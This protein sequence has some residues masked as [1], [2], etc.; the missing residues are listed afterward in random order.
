MRQLTRRVIARLRGGGE[1]DGGASSDDLRRTHELYY[2]AF[3]GQ[4]RNGMVLADATSMRVIDVNPALLS[5]TGFSRR[6]MAGLTLEDLFACNDSSGTSLALQ[7]ADA[8]NG[9]V[10]RWR[11][12]RTNAELVEVEV[13]GHTV[14]FE[15][16]QILALVIHDASVRRKVEAHSI[17]NQQ[18][19]D[20]LAHHDQLTGL[21]NRHYLAA[22]LPEAIAKAQVSGSTLAILFIDLDHFKNVNDS[23]GHEVGDK[24]LQEVAR[25]IVENTSSDDTVVRMGGD[26]FIVVVRPTPEASDGQQTAR[27]INR[28]LD[29]PINVNG[30][31]LVATASIG[32]SV[33]PRDGADMGELL[34]HSDSAMY[35]A[36]ET[37]RNQFQMFR[38]DMVEKVQKRVALEG[39]LR[40]AIKRNQFDVSY[41]PI[42]DLRSQRVAGLEALVRWIH[43]TR[44]T[45]APDQFIEVAED[46]G[47][48][49]P[50]G[51]FVL[52]HVMQDLH[53]WQAAGLPLVPVSINI[54]AAQLNQGDL[55]NVIAKLLAANGFGPEV[56][57]LELT[58]RAMFVAGGSRRSDSHRDM[59]AE[60]RASGVRISLDDFGTGYSSLS[61]LKQWHVDKLKIDRSFIRDVV[62]DPNDFAI[63]SAILAIARQMRIEVV[64]EGIESY[65]QVQKLEP[66]GCR[67]GQGYLF[68]MPKPAEDCTQLLKSVRPAPES[69]PDMYPNL[70][71]ET[72]RLVMPAAFRRG[73]GS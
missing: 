41:Q 66:L 39:A 8:R 43:P 55:A 36:K 24:L 3:A 27:R 17:E 12:K 1:G 47:L 45:I 9:T 15:G 34:K 56:I 14:T 10:F 28:A 30:H 18:R 31:S 49:V 42:I 67:F 26:E 11:E 62:H 53:T 65:Q 6:D 2:Q 46:S 70:L 38:A 21:P 33:Y 54:S 13:R 58:E 63:V 35:Q 72:G 44:G 73:Q 71:D 32:V 51:A 40:A 20:H 23:R 57:E 59:I 29:Q 61:Y 60:L 48:I 25:R 50:I 64:A 19:L 5:R 69:E 7:L 52:R 22:F 68:A 37:G 4:A 16:R